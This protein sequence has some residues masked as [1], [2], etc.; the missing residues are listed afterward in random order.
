MFRVVLLTVLVVFSTTVW[1]V[2][3]P[4]M[5]K[6]AEY[7]NKVP[8]KKQMNIEIG[9]DLDVFMPVYYR[10]CPAMSIGTSMYMIAVQFSKFEALT[11]R[12]IFSNSPNLL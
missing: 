1:V 4:V 5:I 3:Q 9:F 7:S 6:K 2:E 12:L 11:R 8:A 10:I